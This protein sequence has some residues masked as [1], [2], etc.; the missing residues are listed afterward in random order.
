LGNSII[1]RRSRPGGREG[2]KEEE[3]SGKRSHFLLCLQK[4]LKRIE[5]PGRE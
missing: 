4:M 3:D 1:L 2:S 5:L